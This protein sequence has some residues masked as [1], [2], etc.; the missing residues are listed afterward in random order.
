MDRFEGIQD[1]P[2]NVQRSEDDQGLILAFTGKSILRDPTEVLQPILLRVLEEA[3]RADSR[4]VLDFRE[5]TYMNSSTFTPLIKTLER[6]RLGGSRV[7]VLFSPDKKWQ[8]VSFTALTIF[9]TP[10]GRIRVEGRP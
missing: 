5:L 6:A 1:G 3:D 10:D 9:D 2:L 4:L 8:S 7:T